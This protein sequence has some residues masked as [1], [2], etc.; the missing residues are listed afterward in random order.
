MKG[1]HKG[2]P[3][4]N[5]YEANGRVFDMVKKYDSSLLVSQEKN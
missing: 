3:S 4:T 2:I 1:F 5:I